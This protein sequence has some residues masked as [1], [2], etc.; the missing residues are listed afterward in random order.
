M[1]SSA[2]L[3]KIRKYGWEYHGLY[4]YLKTAMTNEDL[5]YLRES[6]LD[7]V[8]DMFAVITGVDLEKAKE[9]FADL[10]E[11]GRVQRLTPPSLGSVIVDPLIYENYRNVTEERAKAIERKKKRKESAEPEDAPSDNVSES[12]EPRLHRMTDEEVAE[13][14]GTDI[15]P[16]SGE[17][18]VHDAE[19]PF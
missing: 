12:T 4:E 6:E 2:Y 19:L 13:F 17:Y 10:L 15:D 5:F 1:K 11:T 16:S 18:G 14:F 9:I 8:L 7:D 3:A